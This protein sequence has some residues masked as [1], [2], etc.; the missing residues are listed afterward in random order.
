MIFYLHAG[1]ISMGFLLMATGLVTA[2]YLKKKR[3][4]LRAHKTLEMLSSFAI[5]SGFICGIL[6]VSASGSVHFALAHAYVGACVFMLALVTLVV[7]FLQFRIRGQAALFRPIHRWS[8]R[9]TG[10]LYL[11]NIGLGLSLAGVL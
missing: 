11:A 4:W 2:R 1:L 6:V 9:L 8:G 7:G 5:V 10:V 3:W